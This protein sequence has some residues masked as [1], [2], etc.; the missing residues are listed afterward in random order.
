[1][2]H[3]SDDSNGPQQ[4][5]TEDGTQRNPDR[6]LGLRLETEDRAAATES[7][8]L[9]LSSRAS[10]RSQKDRLREQI[11]ELRLRSAIGLQLYA[12]EFA[13][14]KVTDSS[15]RD[16]GSEISPSLSHVGE[17]D[18]Y[19]YGV[20]PFRVASR[21]HQRSAVSAGSGPGG[22]HKKRT[23]SEGR[24]GP[25]PLPFSAPP[26]GL[27]GSPVRSRPALYRYRVEWADAKRADFCHLCGSEFYW[28][29]LN[30][31]NCW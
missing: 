2:L 23:P 12:E 20:W 3:G 26:V 1:M 11:E 15:G 14:A 28:F 10:S 21:Q 5:Q 13:S 16:V 31:R 4:Q 24:P 8:Q 27:R 6:N 29:R 25:A 7:P 30:A 9:S 17:G 22:G 18:A 19:A